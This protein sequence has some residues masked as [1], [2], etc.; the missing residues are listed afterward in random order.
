MGDRRNYKQI[1]KAIAFDHA[2]AKL[3]EAGLAE[4]FVAAIQSDA[5]LMKAIDKITPRVPTAPMAD[6]SCC[7]TVSSPIRNPGGEVVN[8]VIK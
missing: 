6:W 2:V 4:K 1:K 7:I 3:Q 8:P 5:E